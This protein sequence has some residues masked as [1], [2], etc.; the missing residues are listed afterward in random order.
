MGRTGKLL[1]HHHEGIRADIVTLGKALGGGLM[2]VSAV[3]AD[4]EIML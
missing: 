2:P 4:D 3:L 1:S